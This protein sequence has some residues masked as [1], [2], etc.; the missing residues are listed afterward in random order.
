V[1]KSLGGVIGNLDPATT[2]NCTLFM[3]LSNREEGIQD[4]SMFTCTI[5]FSPNFLEVAL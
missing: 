4:T 5:K 2:S 1:E 3:E